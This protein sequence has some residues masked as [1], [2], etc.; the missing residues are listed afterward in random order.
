MFC[1][2]GENPG[3]EPKK[4]R[5]RKCV[6]RLPS[7]K[8]TGTRLVSSEILV[9]QLSKQKLV[10]YDGNHVLWFRLKLSF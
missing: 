5:F 4:L 7:L 6:P 9:Y 2:V 1:G 3:V 10:P 8:N